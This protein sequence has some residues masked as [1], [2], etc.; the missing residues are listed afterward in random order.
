LIHVNVFGWPRQHAISLLGI[1]S[2]FLFHRLADRLPPRMHQPIDCIYAISP[3]LSLVLITSITAL[4]LN[5]SKW[6]DH[7]PSGPPSSTPN[8]TH[9]RLP[10]PVASWLQDCPGCR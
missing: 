7:P 3:W 4:M 10:F 5:P 8:F 9:R 6:P 2:A 1:V